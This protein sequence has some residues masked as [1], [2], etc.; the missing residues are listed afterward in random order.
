MSAL[1]MQDARSCALSPPQVDKLGGL[2]FA[3]GIGPEIPAKSGG[4][5]SASPN[6]V[7]DLG[8]WVYPA[9][10]VAPSERPPELAGWQKGPVALQMIRR[11]ALR[12]DRKRPSVAVGLVCQM[13][14]QEA[15]RTFGYS[16]KARVH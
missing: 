9:E 3:E 16:P 8:K 15:V 10:A 1:A 5:S 11:S 4:F 7:S 14:G 12:P 6:I 2:F 13:F